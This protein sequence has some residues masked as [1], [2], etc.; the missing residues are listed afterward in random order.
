M[1]IRS[2][3]RRAND[4]QIFKAVSP[5]L[6]IYLIKHVLVEH[7]YYSHESVMNYLCKSLTYEITTNKTHPPAIPSRNLAMI[8]TIKLTVT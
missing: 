3:Y 2:K 7:S 8:A 6:T 4:V 5:T 1:E